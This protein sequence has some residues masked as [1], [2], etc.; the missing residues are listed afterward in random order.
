[1]SANKIQTLNE[2]QL[3]FSQGFQTVQ[4]INGK[5]DFQIDISRLEII[6]G[7]E[8]PE[9]LLSEKFKE[10]KKSQKSKPPKPTLLNI[11]VLY[12]GK[13]FNV[14][15][16][17]ISKLD[18]YGYSEN[19]VTFKYKI[20]VKIASSEQNL[21]KLAIFQRFI[22]LGIQFKLFQVIFDIKNINSDREFLE[23]FRRKIGQPVDIEKHYGRFLEILENQIII[24]KPS[25]MT[26]EEPSY[27]ASTSIETVQD[28]Y[29]D[30]INQVSRVCKQL[31]ENE[32]SKE[33]RMLKTY[34]S[35]AC[36]C[37]SKKKP[38]GCVDTISFEEVKY[39]KNGTLVTFDQYVWTMV[40]KVFT[41][42]LKKELQKNLLESNMKSFS[43]DE[44]KQAFTENGY[45]QMFKILTAAI[46]EKVR[47][48]MSVHYLTSKKLTDNT[49]KFFEPSDFE[50]KEGSTR[51]INQTRYFVISPEMSC[52]A[53][54]MNSHQLT[55]IVKEVKFMPLHSR[56]N[57]MNSSFSTSFIPDEDENFEDG[58]D[59]F[60]AESILDD[61]F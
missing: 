24:R 29:L 36:F 2:T 10:R 7:S 26:L 48:P 31:N 45:A 17:K 49:A 25:K 21:D 23:E 3:N 1:M 42:E 14:L 11:N 47:I 46:N 33:Q 27:E 52:I 4:L 30:V 61:Q 16:K 55:W 37:N 59:T 44:I 40:F 53:G 20:N 39:I 41:P 38:Y 50:I 15:V 22:Q 35:M 5:S 12:K 58:A 54:V 51:S 32:L 13:P 8:I 56:K 34:F 28:F 60:E 6:G 43:K 19:E 18:K 57:F 9:D